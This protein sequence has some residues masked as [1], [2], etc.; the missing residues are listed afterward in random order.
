M[1]SRGTP[2]FAPLHRQLGKPPP[3]NP[4][5]TPTEPRLRRM[6]AQITTVGVVGLGTMGAGIAEVFARAGLEVIGVERD[7]QALAAGRGHLDTS[8]ARA[9]KRGKLTEADAEAFRNRVTFTTDLAAL[10]SA[11]LVIEAV[12]ER[13]ELKRDLFGR[14]DGIVGAGTVLATNTSSLSVTAISVA[15]SRPE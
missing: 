7:D 14:L 2:N 5:T 9:V 6:S 3:T 15:V 10:S 4:A 1:G 11:G 8:T 12:P 13:L